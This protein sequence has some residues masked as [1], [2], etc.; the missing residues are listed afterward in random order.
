MSWRLI[1]RSARL[2]TGSSNLSRRSNGSTVVAIRVAAAWDPAAGALTP[3]G[4][5]PRGAIG[6][7]GKCPGRRRG[8][9]PRFP[10]LWREQ[11]LRWRRPPLRIPRVLRPPWEA[12]PRILRVLSRGPQGVL[13]LGTARKHL[14]RPGLLRSLRTSST[15]DS[16]SLSGG[17]SRGR[18][19]V[20]TTR[21]VS[22]GSQVAF[23]SPPSAGRTTRKATFSSSMAS[24]VALSPKRVRRSSN[25]PSMRESVERSVSSSPINSCRR[26]SKARAR[27]C[28]DSA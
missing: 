11:A 16:G 2:V 24:S 18:R 15:T 25:S 14:Q 7:G 1:L 4:E 12:Q 26:C 27:S 8:L 17:G 21:T 23:S 22:P 19:L 3:G 28:A 10:P 9:D 6:A 13:E 5:N 20:G